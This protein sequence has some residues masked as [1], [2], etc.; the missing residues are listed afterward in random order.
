[1]NVAKEVFAL[2]DDSD[3]GQAP[4]KPRSKKKTRVDESR[5][6]SKRDAIEVSDDDTAPVPAPTAPRSVANVVVASESEE[7]KRKAEFKRLEA[8][9]K[10]ALQA[11]KDAKSK[12]SSK[13]KPKKK[14]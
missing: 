12:K 3:S 9:A 8:A 10:A 14:R 13:S 2:D 1:M 11:T 4:Q 6:G 7:L 5:K